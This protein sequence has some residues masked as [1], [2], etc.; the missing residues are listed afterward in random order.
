MLEPQSSDPNPA[1]AA[2]TELPP[3][4]PGPLLAVIVPT[5]NEAGN[6]AVLVDK[7]RQAL[8]ELG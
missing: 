5:L 4:F 7:L 6:I 8:K 1:P 3:P 2:I